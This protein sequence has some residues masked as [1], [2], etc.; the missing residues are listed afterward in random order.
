MFNPSLLSR[1]GWKPFFQQQLSLQEFESCQIARVSSVHQGHIECLNETGYFT[2]PL[3]ASSPRLATGD[4]ILIDEKQHISRCLERFSQIARKSAGSQLETQLMVSNVDTAFIVCSLNDDFSLNRIERYLALCKET[5]I[6]PVVVLTKQDLCAD[7]ETQVE[8]VQQLDAQ[9]AVFAVNALDAGSLRPLKS[10]CGKGNTLCFLGSS[11]VGKSTLV[12]SLSDKSEQ[13]TGNIRESDSK[14]RHTTTQ[15]HII[16]LEDGGVLIDTP[17]MRELQIVNCEEGIKHTFTDIESLA[18]QCK[19]NDCRHSNEPGCAVLRAVEAGELDR[20]RL[21]NYQKLLREE[22]Y[23]SA[24]IAEKREKERQFGKLCKTV[25][26]F[27]NND[28]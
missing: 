15:R 27:K 6:T 25:M 18:Q 21:E 10:F 9:L 19:F 14:G 26:K 16:P 12:N 23:N 4:W 22:A 24:S 13:A 17:G 3:L 7:W 20:R 28:K 1:Y 5:D 8:Q 2:L 11:G